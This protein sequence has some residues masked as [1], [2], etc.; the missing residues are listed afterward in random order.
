MGKEKKVKALSNLLESF[1]S[2]RTVM[3]VSIE[4]ITASQL[5]EIKKELKNRAKIFVVKKKVFL[6]ALENLEKE[7]P[8]VKKM[9]KYVAKPFAVIVSDEDAFEISS[10]LCEKK[11]ER[12]AKEGDVALDDVV[13][14]KGLTDMPVGPLLHK[15][16]QF[17]IK[18]SVEKGKIAIKERKVL[19]KKGEKIS[20]EAASIIKE[21]ELK[22]FTVILKPLVAFDGKENKI[23]ENIEINK[24]EILKNLKKVFMETFLI[25]LELEYPTKETINV[26]L[27]KANQE[28]SSLSSLVS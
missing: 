19:V 2:K 17:G 14:E 26:L 3:L 6:K 10:F 27:Q 12:E 18:A 20:A 23:Y 1:K 9:E 21:L 13:L 24:E 4:R 22:P 16:T 28:A 15:L 7:K 11:F 5:Q 8:I 25:A